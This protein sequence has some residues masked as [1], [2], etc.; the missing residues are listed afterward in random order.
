MK[1]NVL[2]LFGGRSAERE[3]SLKT[4]QQVLAS[5][6]RRKYNVFPQEI[7]RDNFWLKKILERREEIDLIFLAVHGGQEENG[8]L[9]GLLEYLGFRYT[10]SRVLSSSL[11]MNKWAAMKIFHQAGFKVPA[12]VSFKLKE[13]FS[14]S[15]LSAI[16]QRIKFPLILKPN[17]QGS[18]V[19]VMKIDNENDF[20]YKLNELT[21][22]WSSQRQILL[23][24]YIKGRELTCGVISDQ[25]YR[26]LDVFPVTEIKPTMGHFFDW[27]AKYEVGGAEEI[28]PA[29][30]NDNL[31]KLVQAQAV[32]A[33]K[34]LGCMGLTRTDF[35]LSSDGQLYILEINT[36]PGLTSLS[37]CPQ[38]AKAYGWSFSR[39]LDEI[40][41]RSV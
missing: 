7:D 23:Q 19:G 17:D 15:K 22:N 28:T 31:T 29:V 32:K 20:D 36:L 39:L 13:N 5:L 2:V 1:L 27:Q 10:G 37:L 34:L 40:I 9:Q 6:D 24:K 38:Q 35:M 16:K 8:A 4:G 41:D 21:I 3:V 30:I 14:W 18:S 26:R 25:S 12:T 11:G 33:H